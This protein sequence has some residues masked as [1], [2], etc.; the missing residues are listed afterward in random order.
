[1]LQSL[2]D[3]QRRMNS[4]KWEVNLEGS[5]SNARRRKR[6][7]S[8]LSNS[9]GSTGGSSSSSHRNKRKRHYRN[10]SCDEFKKERPPTFN[11]EIQN[12]QEA[13]AW[14]LKMRKYFKVQDYSRNM[15]AR[16]AIFNLTG[17]ESMWWDTLGK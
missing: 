5:R 13:E 11:G 7:S 15:K 2:I 3:I 10:S 6:P 4:E 1:M 14:L 9:K 12:D 16:V 8:G 17:R